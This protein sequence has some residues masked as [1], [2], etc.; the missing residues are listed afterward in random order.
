M[1]LGVGVGVCTVVF[2]SLRAIYF[3][4][5]PYV[6]SDGIVEV[7]AT[8]SPASNRRVDA[9][10]LDRM[11]LWRNARAFRTLETF[12]ARGYTSLV[13]EGELPERVPAEAVSAPFFEILGVEPTIG[14]T[15]GPDDDRP[16]AE[17]TA[18]LSYSLWQERFDGDRS[19]LG[20]AVSLSGQAYVIVGV[21]PLAFQSE[22]RIWVP[23]IDY[24]ARGSITAW[25][26]VGKLRE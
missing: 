7:G 6:G 3:T 8:Q 5:L 9:I 23:A 21:M 17:R 12:A 20:T 22:R 26:P 2:A 24:L 1:S 15:L 25:H 11:R 10:P 19:V 4:P 16:A 13:L 18:V 14:R